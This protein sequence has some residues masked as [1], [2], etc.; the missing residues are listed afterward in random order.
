MRHRHQSRLGALISTVL[1]CTVRAMSA[2]VRRTPQA[3]REAYRETRAETGRIIIVSVALAIIIVA[4][5]RM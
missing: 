2:L 3:A 5:G 1:L 4:V